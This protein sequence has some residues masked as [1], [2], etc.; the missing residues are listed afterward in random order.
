[1]QGR[2]GLTPFAR[3]A[4]GWGLWPPALLAAVLVLALRWLALRQRARQR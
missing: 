4:S 3:W 1:V 2:T